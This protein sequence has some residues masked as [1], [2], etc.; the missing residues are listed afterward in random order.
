[1]SHC[2]D[3][4][5]TMVGLAV[6]WLIIANVLVLCYSRENPHPLGRY[7]ECIRWMKC[8]LLIP[9][10]CCFLFSVGDCDELSTIVRVDSYDCISCPHCLWW[11]HHRDRRSE[12][13]GDAFR[14]QNCFFAQHFLS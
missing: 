12:C 2:R 6:V 5:P 7:K 8:V 3:S 9:F 10:S 13:A 1:M 4:Q 14:F 11:Q